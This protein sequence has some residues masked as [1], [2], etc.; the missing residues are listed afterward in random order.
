MKGFRLC[1]YNDEFGCATI[2]TSLLN[3]M[4]PNRG[5]PPSVEEMEDSLFEIARTGARRLL[6]KAPEAEIE[7][8][9]ER[10]CRAR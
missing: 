1:R 6:Q 2:L 4:T 9:S 8:P 10:A 3:P 5:I 7:V